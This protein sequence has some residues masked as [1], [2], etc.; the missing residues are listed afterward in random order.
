LGLFLDEKGILRCRGRLQYAELTE[1]SQC[2]ILLPKKDKFTHLLIEKHHTEIMHCGVSQTLS[3]LR[4]KYWIPQGRATVKL[5]IR[6]CCIC[7]RCEGGPYKVPDMP[8]LPKS[9]VTSSPPFIHTGLDYLGPLYIKSPVEKKKIWVCLFTCLATRAIHLEL[10]EDMSSGEF[11]LAFR[12]FISQRGVPNTVI[13]DNALQFKTASTTLDLLWTQTLKHEAVL[14]YMSE[15]KVKWHFI[16][17]RAPWFGGFYERLVGLVKRSLRKTL[18]RKLL[19]LIQMITVLKEVE[20]IVNARPLVYI[21]DD[22]DSNIALTPN[23]FLTLNPRVSV[24]DFDED[25]NDRSY[26]PLGSSAHKLLAMWHK[27]KILL[28][29]FWKLWRDEYLLSLRERLQTTI[30]T[31]RIQ[32][33][34]KPCV[35]DIILVKDELPRSCWKMGKITDLKISNDGR[36]RSAEVQLASGKIIRRPLPL[37]YPLETSEQ[38]ATDTEDVQC[39][40]SNSQRPIR[41]AAQRALDIIKQI[42]WFLWNEIHSILNIHRNEYSIQSKRTFIIVFGSSVFLKTLD[43]TVLSYTV[44]RTNVDLSAKL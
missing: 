22:I 36:V 3:K 5:V 40:R 17:E 6:Q 44:N 38:H 30:K 12:R 27:G 29:K 31:H 35:G 42:N 16:T 13:S 25:E 4:H 20:A 14:S 33:S 43:L 19:T 11:L 23:H 15:R 2:P 21:S 28:D 26:L 8:P 9:R 32:S 24:P 18:G 1:G 34:S 7:R 41:L 37:L 10:V 39:T